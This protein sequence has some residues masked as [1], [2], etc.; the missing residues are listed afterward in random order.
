MGMNRPRRRIVLGV[1]LLLLPMLLGFSPPH[2]SGKGETLQAGQQTLSPC[3]DYPRLWCGTLAVPLD[4]DDPSG[5]TIK[6]GFAWRPAE[7]KSRGTLVAN[8][9]G[10]GYPSITSYALWRGIFKPLLKDHDLLMVDARGAGLSRPIV[11]KALQ[12]FDEAQTDDEFHQAIEDCGRQLDTSF[13]RKNGEF[14]HASDLFGAV[15]AVDDM[16]AVIGALKAGPVDLYGDSYGSFFAQAF[17]ARHPNLLRSVVLDGTWPL[18]D[19]DPWYPET[20]RTL[21]FAFDAVCQRSAACRAAAPGSATERLGLLADEL[22]DAPISGDVPLSGG[23][24]A[25]V[26]VAA[27]DIAALAW[28]AG[29]DGGIYCD[30]DAAGR[31]ARDGDPLPLLRLAARTGLNGS[32]SGGWPASAYSVGHAVA[33]P[34]TDYPQMYDMTA[35][36]EERTRQ[37]ESAAAALPADF[38]A[39]FALPQWLQ[40]PIQDYL[41]LI[42]I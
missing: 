19:A 4:R 41:S 34:C 32:L 6:I 11:C 25:S 37:F 7:R 20:P 3:K 33:V 40:N 36:S 30:L 28:S 18:V 10:P 29:S 9:G 22:E 8:E 23:A 21:R 42:H 35:P 13:K 24:S 17:A 26:T 16:A 1:L 31:A 5:G 12:D 15:D 14:V 38:F 27:T 2:A 39:P